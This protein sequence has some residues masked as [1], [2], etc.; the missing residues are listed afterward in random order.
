MAELEQAK[1]AVK[2]VEWGLSGT[3]RISCVSSFTTTYL[4]QDL[5]EFH[6]LHPDLWID[7]QQHDR[8]CDP[9]QD[10]FDLCIQT[11]LPMKGFVER[12]D[13]VPVKRLLVA[14]PEYIERYGQPEKPEELINYKLG[15]NSHVE[16][17]NNV[18]F[19]TEQGV[20]TIKINP[21][22]MTNTPWFLKSAVLNSKCI[23]MLP[24]F[25]IEEEI[26]SGKVVPILPQYRSVSAKLCGYYRKSTFV[27]MKV[28][29]F[30]NFLRRK[31]LECPP[32][33]QRLLDTRPDLISAI[34]P[35]RD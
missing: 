24:V 34:A 31:Y 15:H 5:C 33:E 11:A 10:G 19:H 4:S 3:F 32:W 8:I 27:P 25:F 20:K 9:V 17:E 12:V 23:A 16:P 29:I 2:S 7:L 26:M 22:L 6:T 13:I 28:R 14:T 21:F 35:E 30:L 18:R 1:A